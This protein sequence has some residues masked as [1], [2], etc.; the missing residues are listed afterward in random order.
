MWEDE[1]IKNKQS[2]YTGII[3]IFGECIK[4]FHLLTPQ[5]TS[6][7]LPNVMSSEALP[8]YKP[9]S[10]KNKTF[11]YERNQRVPNI[12]DLQKKY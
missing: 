8:S 5:K 4:P 2:I 1:L 6:I 3:G 10:Y 11:S 7:E 9:I 12:G